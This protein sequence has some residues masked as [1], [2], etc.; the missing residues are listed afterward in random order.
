MITGEHVRLR[1]IQKSDSGAY[2]TWINDREL[3]HY[4]SAWSPI[5][6]F[7]H[8]GWFQSVSQ[9]STI[10][11][12]SIIE[13]E[14]DALIGS[15]SL[16]HIDHLHQNA[17]LQIRIGESDRQGAGLGTEAVR[18]LLD[19]GF[20]DLNLERI[21]LHVFTSNARAIRSYEKAGFTSEGVLRR[22]CFIDGAFRDI[23]VL[24]ILRD[25][26]GSSQA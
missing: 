22:A 13:L 26:F 9:N 25:E 18:L 2:K 23:Q 10:R 6:D 15:C 11:I 12:F 3:V 7:N 1:A 19:F 8:E 4:N 14:N 21:F 17:E 16:R 20:R 24:S 5:S